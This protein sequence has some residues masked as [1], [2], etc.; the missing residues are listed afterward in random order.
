MAHDRNLGDPVPRTGIGI[1][2]GSTLAKVAVA[3]DGALTLS[4]HPV[5]D[6]DALLALAAAHPDAPLAVTGAGAAPLADAMPGRAPA[7]VSEFDAL[8][9]GA[10]ALLA[11]AAL[12]V[13]DPFLVVS[14]GTGTSVVL[15][16]GN[17]ATRVG[18]TAMGGGTLL[19]LGAL[20]CGTDDYATLANL[21]AEGD[22]QMV[23]LL[24]RDV[25]PQ[26]V[27]ELMG[28]LT[29]ANFGRLRSREPQDVAHGLCGLL[30]E[31]LGLMCGALAQL[32]RATE[33]LYCG[34]TLIDNPALTGILVGTTTFAGAPAQVLPDGAYCAALGCLACAGCFPGLE[35]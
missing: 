7:L 25:Y 6:R 27:D 2:A 5:A 17:T 31:N 22:R 16:D 9:A 32:H 33:V 35:E 12:A 10:R 34:A 8:A 18:G 3:V 1:D 24:V 26:G 28:G 13:A 20:L 19:G 14:V 11:R 23:D 21:A 15:V 29:A 30:G 4:R